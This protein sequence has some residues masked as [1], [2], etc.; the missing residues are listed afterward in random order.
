[1]RGHIYK[2]WT[3][4]GCQID[5]E[6]LYRDVTVIQ[7]GH[8]CPGYRELREMGR[9]P[10]FCMDCGKKTHHVERVCRLPEYE[11]DGTIGGI[12]VLCLSVGDLVGVPEY[13]DEDEFADELEYIH[14]LPAWFQ[15]VEYQHYG[16]AVR[17]STSAFIISDLKKQMR[18]I[19]DPLGMWDE[20]KW[21]LWT[22]LEAVEKLTT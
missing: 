10:K 20:R 19:L 4:Y 13:E 15:K 14:I 8:N 6:K 9:E 11:E 12:K 16:V 18:D 2:A 22:V 5:V 21:G 17:N 3:I 1:M 7:D